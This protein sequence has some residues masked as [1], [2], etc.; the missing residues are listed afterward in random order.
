MELLLFSSA[1]EEITS[2]VVQLISTRFPD[3]IVQV[4]KTVARVTELLQKPMTNFVCLVLVIA[5]I[6]ELRQLSIVRDLLK[7]KTV[8][9]FIPDHC[10]QTITLSHSLQPRFI[11]QYTAESQFLFLPDVLEK[12]VRSFKR[13]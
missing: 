6:E 12:I 2:K 8:I 5:S 10:E 13:L 4:F 3:L 1:K 9:L 7:G 11:S